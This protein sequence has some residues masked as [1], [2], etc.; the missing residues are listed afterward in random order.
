MEVIFFVVVLTM[1]IGTFTWLLLGLYCNAREEKEQCPLC[2]SEDLFT[3]D[4]TDYL[5]R[6]Y[7]TKS[8][9]K[10]GWNRMLKD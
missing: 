6:E 9:D 4:Y 1:L 8:C 3:Y 7:K 2:G 5:C 10:C